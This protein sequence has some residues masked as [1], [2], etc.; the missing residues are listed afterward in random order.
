MSLQQTSIPGF[1]PVGGETVES[2][3][4]LKRSLKQRMI[5]FIQGASRLVFRSELCWK[6]VSI[7]CDE[8]VREQTRI[9]NRLL[10]RFAGNEETV[11]QGGAFAGMR[12]GT[13]AVGGAIL[14]KIIGSY[15]CQLS[16]LIAGFPDRLACLAV[17]VVPRTGWE[18]KPVDDL[19]GN[20]VGT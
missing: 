14:P 16:E 8:F 15:E 18:A 19:A 10:E 2:G 13:G 12:Y 20:S 1:N 6:L 4:A 5:G 17:G 9:E 7:V 11:I 3:I